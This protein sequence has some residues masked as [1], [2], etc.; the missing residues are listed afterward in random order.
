MKKPPQEDL[1]RAAEGIRYEPSLYHCPIKG[2]VAPRTKPASRCDDFNDVKAAA[3]TLRESIRAGRV[4]KQWIDGYPR[5]V[6]HMAGETWYEATT[7]NGDPGLY[8]AYKIEPE[9]LPAGLRL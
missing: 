3:R 2:S 6:W 9:G 7:K 1:N 5:F 4:S 8:H